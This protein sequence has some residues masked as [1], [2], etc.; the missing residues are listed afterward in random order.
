MANAEKHKAAAVIFV[1]D[2]KTA[3]KDDPL[4]EFNYARG[5]SAGNF[6][7]IHIKRA[8]LDQLLAQRIARLPRSRPTSIATRSHPHLNSRTP[9]SKSRPMWSGSNGR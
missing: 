7:I 8:V 3:G 9:K 6:P 2:V 1:N 4:M 5:G